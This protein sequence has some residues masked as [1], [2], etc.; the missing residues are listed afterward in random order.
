MIVGI[1]T[2]IQISII[3]AILQRHEPDGT[4]REANC[5]SFE[6]FARYLMDKSNYAFINE[7]ETPEES[8]MTRSMATY[9]IASSHNTYLTGE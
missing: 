1:Q 5:L 8:D 2:D 6:G 7:Q 3:T 4:L 9:Y